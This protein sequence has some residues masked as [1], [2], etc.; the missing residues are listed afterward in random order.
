VQP[1]AVDSFCTILY[2]TQYLHG[3]HISQL[4]PT[5]LR[6]ALRKAGIPRL[7]PTRTPTPTLLCNFVNVY[8]ISYHVQY[9]CTRVHARIPNGHPRD[10][11]REENRTCRTSRRGSSCVSGSWRTKLFLWQAEQGSRRTRRHPRDDP[12][13]EV[14]EGVHVGVRVGAVKCQ[15]NW[16][17]RHSLKVC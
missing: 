3:R 5:E 4:I 16:R 12:L 9:T 6:D 11:P 10:D 17:L 13:A 8:T 14:G 1:R 15:L 7:T 2:I